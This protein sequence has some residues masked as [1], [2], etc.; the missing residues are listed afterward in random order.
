MN[1][2]YIAQDHTKKADD[3]GYATTEILIN[4]DK[5]RRDEVKNNNDVYAS[6]KDELPITEMEIVMFSH[7]D[8]DEGSFFLSRVRLLVTLCGGLG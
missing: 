1:L 5:Q 6:N 4:A 3:T 8:E 2:G 7:M